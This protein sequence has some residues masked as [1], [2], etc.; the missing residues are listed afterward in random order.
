MH[1]ALFSGKKTITWHVQL[2]QEIL[3][4]YCMLAFLLILT[5]FTNFAIGQEIS[6]VEP[7]FWWAGMKNQHLQLMLYGNNLAGLRP[8]INKPGL[9]FEETRQTSNA[10]YLFIDLII[11][12]SVEPGFF[13]IDLSDRDQK[14]IS[15]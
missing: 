13:Q 5:G 6:R 8:T 3:M 4:K 11:S 12:D 10:N 14:V 9:Q 2:T 1:H 7:P 15:C